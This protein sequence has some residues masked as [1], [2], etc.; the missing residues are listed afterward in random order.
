MFD[1]VAFAV[2]VW[3]VR[4]DMMT[5]KATLGAASEVPPNDSK[6]TGQG[7]FDYDASSR[8][9]E[10]HITYSGLSGIATAGH[11]HGPAMVGA[12]AGVAIPFP[13]AISPI[14]G[15]ATLTRTQGGWLRAGRMYVNVHTVAN[16]DGEIR[17]QIVK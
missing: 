5:M 12:N 1:T 10:W 2:G 7:T 11:V 3:A 14:D 17:G 4:A 8:R 6:G 9:L 15:S 13:F 16:P